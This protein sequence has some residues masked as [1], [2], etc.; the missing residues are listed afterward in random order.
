LTFDW[1]RNDTKMLDFVTDRAV[2]I[3]KEAGS[4]DII[5]ENQGEKSWNPYSQHSSRTFGGAV[6]GADP[7]T[8]AVNPYLQSWDAHNLFVV[9]ASAF[10]NNGGY[11]P[12]ITVGGASHQSRTRHPRDLFQEPGYAGQGQTKQ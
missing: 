9:G 1:N 8:S 6:M 10:P 3:M 12:T 11:N 2:R 4:K 7:T 5:I